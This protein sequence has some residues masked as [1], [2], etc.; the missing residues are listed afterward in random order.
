MSESFIKKPDNGPHS[1]LAGIGV[2]RSEQ[3]LADPADILRRIVAW[4]DN[5]HAGR[6]VRSAELEAL[7][8]EGRRAVKT[9][10]PWHQAVLNECMAVESCY[11]EADPAGTV[12]AL[13]DWHVSNAT[14]GV[15][16]ANSKTQGS[17]G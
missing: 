7:I 10:D 15:T 3:S 12:K 16:V 2:L 17:K 6:V 9:S 5:V 1:A 11:R 13:I 14:S 8:E 4:R